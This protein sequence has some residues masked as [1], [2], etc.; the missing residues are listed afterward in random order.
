VIVPLNR[1]ADTGQPIQPP[2]VQR[3]TMSLDVLGRFVCDRWDEAIDNGGAS[4]DAVIVVGG[5]FGG[6]CADK[7]ARSSGDHPLRVVARSGPV[8]GAHA[9]AELT[10]CRSRRAGPDLPVGGQ[11][12]PARDLV[13]GIPWRSNVQFVGLAYCVGGKSLYWGGWCP[14]LQADDLSSSPPSVAQYL[15]QNYPTHEEQVGVADS[16]DFIQGPLF[17]LLKALRCVAQGRIANVSSVQDPPL[18]VQG[19]SPAS[20]LF[21]F[22]KY[23]SVT[24]LID[25]AREAA[26]QSDAACRLFVVANAHVTHLM[27]RTAR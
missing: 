27:W 12:R 21:A 22:D 6:Y 7:I 10:S 24:V 13:W 5:T 2:D 20:G 16:T 15:T 8:S 17:N 1:L 18:A 23:S 11:R 25:A 4:F 9:R 26:G 3:T 19:Q 14:R